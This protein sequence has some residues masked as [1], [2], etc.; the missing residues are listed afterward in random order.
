MGRLASLRPRCGDVVAV[1]ALVAVMLVGLGMATNPARAEEEPL[2]EMVFVANAFDFPDALGAAAV[3][4]SVGAPVVLTGPD[5]LASDAQAA[6]AEADPDLVV[7]VGGTA[8]ISSAVADA[9]ADLGYDVQR[10]AGP[11]R[12]A[13]ARELVAFAERQGFERP[14]VTGRAVDAGTIP[15]LDAESL[16]GLS[17]DE[18]A[19]GDE[20]RLAAVED[21]LDDLEA[22]NATLREEIA[23][24]QDENASLAALLDGVD[25]VEIDGHD[26][27][28]FR[29]MN[30]QIV[31]GAGRTDSD[32]GLGNVLIG[33]SAQR[34]PDS[35]RWDS[36]A[37][38]SGSHYLVIGDRHEWTAYGGILAGEDHTAS[39][40]AASAVGG[41]RNVA[42]GFLATVSGGQGNTA[43]GFAA[44]VSGGLANEAGDEYASVSGGIA[45]EAS[46]I[47]ASVSGGRENVASG[48][49][50]SVSGGFSNTASA[51][52]ASVSGG[53]GNEAAGIQASILGGR[54]NVVSTR[55]RCHPSC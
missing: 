36:P 18:L 51:S 27:L 23:D 52:T 14:V 31:N 5:E 28:R 25:R 34:N 46:D 3:A 2:P 40:E 54:D 53:R 20:E 9:I 7:V 11:H 16:Q 10:V 35:P 15:G 22:E 49:N 42:A 6:L 21:R 37:D 1:A 26:T 32:N 43:S 33:Y 17:P 4:G 19:G 38:R 24:L 41:L 50:A 48:R 29:G 44:S 8:V 12:I 45:N 30:V 55:E 47:G 13:T 39:G